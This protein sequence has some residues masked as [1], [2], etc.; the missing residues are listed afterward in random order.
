MRRT[1]SNLTARGFSYRFTVV[2]WEETSKE[3]ILDFAFDAVLDE[4]GSISDNESVSMGKRGSRHIPIHQEREE[5]S[6]DSV[7]MGSTLDRNDLVRRSVLTKVPRRK[8]FNSH[9]AEA[10][11]SLAYSTY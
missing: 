2:G 6:N 1:Q 9:A 8:S 3:N 11:W 4:T 5:S 10:M 7:R